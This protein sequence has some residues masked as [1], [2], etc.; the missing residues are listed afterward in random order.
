MSSPR[1]SP[2][3][4]DHNATTPVAREVLEAMTPHLRGEFGNP[5]SAHSYGRAAR[6]A[7]DT[8]RRHVAE[9]IGASPSEILFTSGGTESNNLAILGGCGDDGSGRQVV[10]SVIEHPSVTQPVRLLGQQ[11]WDV[12]S[13]GVGRQGRIDVDEAVEAI[14]ESTKLVTIMHS[15]NETGVIQ[16]LEPVVEAAR[17]VGALVH[18]DAA[19]S[20]GK[21]DIDVRQLDVDLLTIAGHKVY[22]PKGVGALYVKKGVELTPVLRGAGHEQGLRPGTEN[23]ASIVGLGEA[24][25]QAQIQGQRQRRDVEKLR[26][27]LWERLRD[28]IPGVEVNGHPQ[29]RLPNTLNVVFPGV[30]AVQ[31]LAFAPQIAASTGSACKEGGAAASPVLK[32]MGLSE[33]RALGSLRLALGCGNDAEQIEEAATLLGDAWREC[34]DDPDQPV[35]TG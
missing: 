28:E 32:A 2:I 26:D 24:C 1:Q 33:E 4:L 34:V 9:T 30:E 12:V 31:L 8:A 27:L 14:D 3:Y 20:I 7:V 13:V 19:Q 18:T 29:K 15:N 21:I 35:V 11:G 5:S 17:E 6:R 23:V 10:T 25:R 16:P 22:A